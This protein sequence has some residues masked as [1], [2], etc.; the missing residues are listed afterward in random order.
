MRRIITK[1]SYNLRKEDRDQIDRL[2]L[3]LSTRVID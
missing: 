2:L 3:R 1:R